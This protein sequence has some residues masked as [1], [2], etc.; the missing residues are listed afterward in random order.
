[1]KNVFKQAQSNSEKLAAQREA[2]ILDSQDKTGHVDIFMQAAAIQQVIN[3]PIVLMDQI[4]S[5]S[6]KEKEFLIKIISENHNIRDLEAQLQILEKQK[7]GSIQGEQDQIRDLEAQIQLI[8]LEAKQKISVEENKIAVLK[9]EIES[10]KRDRGK[11]TGVTV[12]QPPTASLLPSKYKA[13]RNALLAG[14]VGFFFLVFLV[15]FI[16]YL[17]NASKRTQKTNQISSLRL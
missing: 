13:K 1:M 17:I 15:F 9:S 6:F 12:K 16:E 2:I 10:L 7:N 4:R 3:Y 14:A 8:E 5:L 11:I